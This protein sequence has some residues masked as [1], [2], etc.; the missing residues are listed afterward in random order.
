[1]ANYMSSSIFWE[2]LLIANYGCSADASYKKDESCTICLEDLLNRYVI[3][4]NCGHVYHRECVLSNIFIY[5]RHVCP[6]PE[7]T[8]CLLTTG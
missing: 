1:M 8:N 5:N 3:T 6:D 4:L 2:I 7:C